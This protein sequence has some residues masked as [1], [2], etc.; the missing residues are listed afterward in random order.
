MPDSKKLKRRLYRTI[1]SKYRMVIM[2]DATLEEKASFI[3]SPMNI[4]VVLMSSVLIIVIVVVSIISFTDLREYI[5]GYAD[6]NMRKKMESLRQ[7]AD[8]LQSAM[9]SKDLYIKNIKN[10]ISGNIEK[11]KHDEEQI[12]GLTDEIK[13]SSSK[14][15]SIL[16]AEVEQED[17]F[18]ITQNYINTQ[19]SVP[20]ISGFL[21]F[22]PLNGTITDKFDAKKR[23]FGI[24]I[25][26]PE[27][28]PIKS[29]LD[30]TVIL[31][32]WT[33][34]TGYIICIQHNNNLF[35]LYKHNSV[36]LRQEGDKVKAG[37]P[38]A[39]IGNT[40]E[41]TTGPHLHFELWFNGSALN[42]EDYIRF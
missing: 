38:I 33:L 20:G 32:S 26:A 4:F 8:S 21:F 31:T 17:M 25:V 40:G 5:P 1:K 18:N 42:P 12:S 37:E 30:G 23:H 41:I 7:K 34:E 36:L 22:T 39:I 35:S 10:I 11:T 13:Y 3:L 2:N 27:N 19:N 29:T 14:E 16:R 24:D 6:V 9:G 28:E 15:D